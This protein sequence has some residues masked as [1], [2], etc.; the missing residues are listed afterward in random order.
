MSL[1]FI[2][3]KLG[4]NVRHHARRPVEQGFGVVAESGFGFTADL[5]SIYKRVFFMFEFQILAG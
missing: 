3:S 5:F 1:V 4:R 2:R